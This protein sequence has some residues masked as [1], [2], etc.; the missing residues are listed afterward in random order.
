MKFLTTLERQF[1]NI[2]RG[3]LK[4]I[5]E[6]LPSL[7]NGLKL[8]WTISRHIYQAESKFEEIL[9][10]ISNEICS[11]VRGKIQINTIFKTRDIDA[12]ITLIE[13]GIA[14]LDKWIQEF[15]RTR[16][17]IESE[18]SNQLWNF[19]KLKDIFQKP[20]HMKT[21]LEDLKEACIILKEFQAILGPDLKA[22]TGSSTQ[23]DA[24][25][26][27]VVEQ[28]R[29]LENFVNDV[30]N[31]EYLQEWHAT[32]NA[33]KQAVETIDGKTST[34]IIDTFK[35]NL[36]SSQGAFDLLS[37]FKNVKTRKRIE[38][39]LSQKYQD[40]LVRYGKELK[41]IEKLFQENHKNPPIPKNMPPNSGSIAWARSLITRI[42]TPIDKFKTKADILTSY[43][44]GINAAKDYVRIARILN[45]NHEQDLFK[46]WKNNNTNDAIEMLKKP[47]LIKVGE[48]GNKR[49]KVNF[50]PR[51]KVIIRE[52][53]FLDRIG[54]VI[55]HT[56]INI[57]LQEKDY[58]R[59]IDKL[60]QLLRNYDS[61]LGN[62]QPI[63]KK[64]LESQLGELNTQMDK[65]EQNHNWFS[66]S[67][68]E[69][70]ERCVAAIDEFKATKTRVLQQAQN[71]EKN[72]QNIENAVLIRS[73]DF[74]NQKI[75]S[76]TEFTEFFEA[77]RVRVLQEL[78][79]DYQTIGE[80]YL[81]TIEDAAFRNK[82]TEDPSEQ[83]KT[84][85]QYWERRIFNAITKMTI[86]ALAANKAL[87]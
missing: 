20:K 10:A 59:Q 36:S 56:I 18:T 76:H 80:T 52:A 70:I 55:P 32:F 7:L 29:K 46:Q 40:V 50:D 73:I 64:L 21:I 33:F 65:G 15:Q 48:S 38:D 47:I 69:Y 78:V 30:F 23:I 82:D 71:I 28:T 25:Y 53:K 66:L 16:M 58:M 49:Y 85:Y 72:V 35:S 12:A 9:E 51:L 13:Q 86:R 60:N 54:K 67:I 4:S 24:V 31:H 19:S 5:E 43:E 77:H 45:E 2:T 37:K 11:K 22:V 14:V 3:D 8:I 84:Y 68:A 74:E 26:D 42:K 6:T 61:A 83:M 63:Q 57:A 34:L 75:M 1:K 27:D 79:K 81:R 44:E 87:W 62:L 41:D 39:V 17:K